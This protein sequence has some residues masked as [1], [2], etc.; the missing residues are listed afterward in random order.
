MVQKQTS[1]Q[2]FGLQDWWDS[3]TKPEQ[4]VLG[5]VYGQ[6]KGAGK[7]LRSSTHDRHLDI[8]FLSD[9]LIAT[10][11]NREL[12]AKIVDKLMERYSHLPA[13]DDLVDD[14]IIELHHTQIRVM[15]YFYGQRNYSSH[16]FDMVLRIAQ[17]NINIEARVMRVKRER[18]KSAI[19]RKAAEIEKKAQDAERRGEV[20]QAA[21]FHLEARK[22]R[23]EGMH[24]S[25]TFSEEHPCF[26]QMA[27]IA[28]KNNDFD[29]ALRIA[30][31]A[32]R[33]GWIDRNED[34]TRRINRLS[35]KISERDNLRHIEESGP[36]GG[37]LGVFNLT[38][39]IKH[40]FAP[41]ERTLILNELTNDGAV[42]HP[43]ID[44]TPEPDG[45]TART[46][47]A[48]LAEAA[49][50]VLTNEHKAITDHLDAIQAHM[51]RYPKD[52]A[53]DAWERHLFFGQRALEC[54]AVV[55]GRTSSSQSANNL[56]P[57]LMLNWYGASSIEF[58]DVARREFA[59][60]H[61][62]DN[63]I[64]PTHPGRSAILLLAEAFD[65]DEDIEPIARESLNGGWAGP[66]E[67][68]LARHR[69]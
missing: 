30:V 69:R 22:K 4:M 32:R 18:V 66:W 25:S 44:G 48:Q 27:I 41:A 67:A 14:A 24:E 42:K 12:Q 59:D 10:N 62:G 58:E 36:Y 20:L 16:A 31:D 40:E 19:Y 43:L 64:K 29:L 60:K 7:S 8:A 37:Y 33:A 2:Y 11:K 65:L 38:G 17:D 61:P 45:H 13:P 46:V 56:D 6:Q 50:K 49:A 21:S 47:L 52:Q 39:F 53:D 5:N 26:R 51:E 9:L 54:L 55:Q 63:E 15:N 68:V 1:I 34:W 28:E 3:L 35:K 57:L 23:I